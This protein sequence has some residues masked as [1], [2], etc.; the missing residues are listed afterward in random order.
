[1]RVPM[2]RVNP[3]GKVTIISPLRFA[4]HEEE[5]RCRVTWS[6]HGLPHYQ[7]D[8]YLFLYEALPFYQVLPV[9][10][11]HIWRV[12]TIQQRSSARSLFAVP[13]RMIPWCPRKES[14]SL[15][16]KVL[17]PC[18]FGPSAAETTTLIFQDHEV[19]Q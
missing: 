15:V 8:T 9:P 1:M 10:T 19:R 17:Y 11:P 3:E 14:V 18:S 13:V 16:L 4:E 2:G 12:P 6:H 7:I 5:G